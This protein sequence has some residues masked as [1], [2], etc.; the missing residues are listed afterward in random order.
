M[1][2]GEALDKVMLKTESLGWMYCSMV[3]IMVSYFHFTGKIISVSENLED[4][5]YPQ[6]NQA[7][8]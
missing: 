7:I 6:F 2:V 8:R 5:S 4:P 3:D 1:V